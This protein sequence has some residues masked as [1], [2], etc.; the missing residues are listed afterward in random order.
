MISQYGQFVTKDEIIGAYRK[1]GY[2]STVL[3]GDLK[4]RFGQ[5]K[6]DYPV[7]VTYDLN[8]DGTV[9]NFQVEK[10]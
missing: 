9:T 7:L 8:S 4:E 2:I 5:H 1:Y 6:R 10:Y 3:E